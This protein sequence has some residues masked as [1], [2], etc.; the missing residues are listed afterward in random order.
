MEPRLY[1]RRYKRILKAAGVQDYTF[2]TLRHTFATRWIDN[3][4]DVKALC[5]ILG[6]SNVKTTLQRY[7]HPSMESKRQQMEKL[8]ENIRG[9]NSC[10]DDT[11][12]LN[13]AQIPTGLP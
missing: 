9:Q 3:G 10:Q 6:H 4:F 5:E 11:Q 8:A 2:H 1:L 12:T 7:V 13:F